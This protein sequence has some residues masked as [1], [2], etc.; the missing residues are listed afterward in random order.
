MRV[1]HFS[2]LILLVIS[3]IQA[4]DLTSIGESLFQTPQ[5]IEEPLPE[6]FDEDLPELST[7][8]S[9][10]ETVHNSLAEYDGEPSTVVGGCVN[11]ISG[12]F[13]HKTNDM[14]I[15]GPELITFGRTYCSA[16]GLGE[17]P[18]SSWKHNHEGSVYITKNQIDHKIWEPNPGKEYCGVWSGPSGISLSFSGPESTRHDVCLMI[19]ANE[20]KKG[21]AHLGSMSGKY[22]INNLKM[23]YARWTLQN[24]CFLRKGDGTTYA[25]KK[26]KNQN[27]FSLVQETLPD[28]NQIKYSYDNEHRLAKTDLVNST[29]DCLS[30]FKLLYND[31]KDKVTIASSNGNIGEYLFDLHRHNKK[32]YYAL[33][34]FHADGGYTEHYQ[35]SND[36]EIADRQLIQKRLPDGRFLNI[37]YYKMG[38]NHQ[39]DETVTIRHND[40]PRI[41]RVSKLKAPVGIGSEEITCY[42]FYYDIHTHSGSTHVYDPLDIKTTYKYNK[43]KRLDKIIKYNK[44]DRLYST[45]ELVW[46]AGNS[47]GGKLSMRFLMDSQDYPI[48]LKGYIY[49]SFGNIIQETTYGNLTGKE[50]K[51]QPL[52]VNVL[53]LMNLEHWTNRSDK[54]VKRFEYSND[55]RNL[56]LKEIESRKTVSYQYLKGKNLFAKRFT[57]DKDLIRIRQFYKY[58]QNNVLIGEIVDDGSNEQIQNL[59]GVT[60]RRIK[61]IS[62][63][64]TGTIG[65]P[66]EVCE[67]YLNLKT[68]NKLLFKH[69]KNHYTHEGHL[70]Q[71]DHYDS[72]D[73][74]VYSLYWQYNKQ[75]KIVSETDPIG[76]KIERSYDLNGNLVFEQLYSTENTK[77]YL[78][79]YANRLIKTIHHASGIDQSTTFTYDLKGQKTSSTNPFGNTSK[80]I[81]DEF[82]RIV[83]TQLPL[84]AGLQNQ[85]E[86]PKSTAQYN[87]LGQ[88][89][90]LTD[91]RNYQ[92][93]TKYTLRGQP[94]DI[95]YPDG[96]TLKNKYSEDGLLIVKEEKDHSQ[97]FY[98]YDFLGRLIKEEMKDLNGT[99]LRMHE[100]QYNAFHL[101]Q[102]IDSEGMQTSYVYDSAGRQVEIIK[103][104]SL[105]VNH[106][107]ALGRLNRVEMYVDETN[108]IAECYLYDYVDRVV[109]KWVEDS[110]GHIQSKVEYGYDIYDNKVREAVHT[111]E[112]ISVTSTEYNAL[113]QPTKHI[114]PQGRE[115]TFSTITIT[116]MNTINLYYV[117]KRSTQLE[118]GLLPFMIPWEG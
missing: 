74:Y 67:Y 80:Y 47:K 26:Y 28:G 102:E 75:G 33:K 34:T 23:I 14:A 98:E 44:D 41:R 69:V 107:D 58:D 100:Y 79:D 46:D 70:I 77:E 72:N 17:K 51:L 45:E 19:K 118:E 5:S 115:N 109:M 11:V 76:R 48:L 42:R 4:L 86:T 10:T 88:P 55:G 15:L 21:L 64:K 112:G 50:V 40:D 101:I 2:T 66:E 71:Q 114:D 106:Y 52:N 32:L 56:L 53:R 9:S 117:Q 22:N 62:P 27:T 103:G 90:K 110:S 54:E 92:T 116:A 113:G 78:Y 97:V 6:F 43:E 81:Y 59:E 68:G 96:T 99:S 36:K 57:S 108:Y 85:L 29:G 31:Q 7:S 84:V 83:E 91:P 61:I 20:Y 1:I 49:D 25:F 12:S 16:S 38:N 73:L 13:I 3:R 95:R 37:D 82:G 89:I 94:Y 104:D 24:Y 60:E 111:D 65:L 93:A 18:F 105:T 63:T 39:A 35:Y 87:T 30:S 8:P